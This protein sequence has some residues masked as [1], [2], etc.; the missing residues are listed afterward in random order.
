M[1]GRLES[2]IIVHGFVELEDTVSVGRTHYSGGNYYSAVGNTKPNPMP[3]I[4]LTTW[5]AC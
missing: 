1:P 4:S 3:R 2:H 5:M